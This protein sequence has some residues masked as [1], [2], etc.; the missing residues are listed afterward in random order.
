MGGVLWQGV[1]SNSETQP[2]WK[3]EQRGGGTAI[4]SRSMRVA[5]VLP[6]LSGGGAQRTFLNLANHLDRSAFQPIVVLYRAEGVLLPELREGVPVVELGC[7]GTGRSIIP[8]ASWLSRAT[9]DVVI[10]T[11]LHVNAAAVLA[12]RLSR[13]GVPIVVRETNNFTA[14][15]RPTGSLSG[16]IIRWTYGRADAIVALSEGVRDDVARRYSLDPG[17]I[18]TIYNPVDLQR[19]RGARSAD[20]VGLP[21]WSD[22]ESASRIIGIGRLVPQKG[23]DLLLRALAGIDRP[24]TLA[25]LGEG[26]AQG[27]LRRLAR[28]LGVSD[29]V[30]FAGHIANPYPYL[31][32]ADLFVLSS[33]WEGFGHV[34]AEAM[35]CETP[36]VA[37]RCPSGPDEIIE[38]GVTGRLCV[39]NS[40][41]ALSEA[42]DESLSDGESRRR[43]V[44]NAAKHVLRFDAR[45]VAAEYGA[46]FQRIRRTD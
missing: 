1:L 29:R 43:Y 5:L 23:F 21:G 22:A 4:S 40:V 31:S 12:V 11:L 35:A 19:I 30:M 15:G 27:D 45:N 25:L 10:S 16:R 26:P 34:I 9:P 18:T 3:T 38:D 42:I 39:P 6:T 14:A 32:Q 41:E 17:R 8:L 33:R 20:V 7:R 44:A 2:R 28:E 36:V 24:W 46:L 13:T 37:T